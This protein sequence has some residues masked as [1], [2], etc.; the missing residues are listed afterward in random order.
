MGCGITQ[1]FDRKSHRQMV[2][3]GAGEPS[4]WAVR[5]NLAAWSKNGLCYLPLPKQKILL[6]PLI[7]VDLSCLPQAILAQN[8][9]PNV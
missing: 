5:S 7:K 8:L 9:T 2:D 1:P 6:N 3:C 4:D